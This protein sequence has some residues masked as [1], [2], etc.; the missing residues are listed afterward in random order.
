[1]LSRKCLLSCDAPLWNFCFAKGRD[2]RVKVTNISTGPLPWCQ[3]KHKVRARWFL[4][5]LL[6]SDFTPASSLCEGGKV[7][8][9]SPYQHG[10]PGRARVA[11][12]EK[13]PE[14]LMKY[15]PYVPGW[16]RLTPWPLWKRSFDLTPRP[17]A[18]AMAS[19]AVF[20]LS[21]QIR[22]WP[23]ICVFFSVCLRLGCM[24]AN[25]TLSVLFIINLLRR[26]T[27]SAFTQPLA[28]PP[29]LPSLTHSLTHTHTH[30]DIICKFNARWAH[31]SR[32]VNE[33]AM[34][35]LSNRC[36]HKHTREM[37]KETWN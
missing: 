12:K 37:T 22:K 23:L 26:Q 27:H 31:A 5:A 3:Q 28:R 13:E 35:K 10:I 16:S 33:R 24:H 7:Q 20:C 29:S 4:T 11:P 14:V 1:M 2:T 32:V 6:S 36:T 15:F 21:L 18:V 9:R 34:C 19:S 8:K 30:S 25:A 17:P